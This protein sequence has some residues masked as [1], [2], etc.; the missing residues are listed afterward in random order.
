MLRPALRLKPRERGIPQRL[1]L[2]RRRVTARGRPKARR[3]PLLLQQRGD[4]GDGDGGGGEEE[5]EGDEEEDQSRKR[6]RRLQPAH[7]RSWPSTVFTFGS[8][9]RPA[10]LYQQAQAGECALRILFRLLK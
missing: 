5:E 1:L 4:G 6:L 7:P 8:V 10:L 2:L 9:R 3:L